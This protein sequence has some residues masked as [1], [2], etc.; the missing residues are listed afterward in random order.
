MLLRFR[1]RRHCI[2]L[3]RL[4]ICQRYYKVCNLI[5]RFIRI[6]LLKED[7]SRICRRLPR[8]ILLRLLMD[9]HMWIFLIKETK[10]L[11]KLPRIFPWTTRIYITQM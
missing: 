1:S 2:I 11:R 8:R 5:F 7:M 4:S 10:F 6:G 3:I 9:T